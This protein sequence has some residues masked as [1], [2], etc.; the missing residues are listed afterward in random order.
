MQAKTKTEPYDFFEPVFDGN[1][2]VPLDTDYNLPD[3]CADIQRILKCR[4]VP[5]ISS[6][7][8][9]GDRVNCDGVCD[10]RVMYLDVRGEG[11][12]CCDFTKEFSASIPS[13]MTSERAVACI[14]ASVQHMTCRAVSAR[15]IDLH[16]TLGLNVLAVVQ[17][18]DPITVAIDDESIEKK[19]EAVSASQAVNAVSHQ[20]TVED[21]V[22]LKSGKPPIENILRREAS[23]RLIE[24]SANEDRLHVNG[25]VDLSFLYN[26]FVDGVTAEKMSATI[27]FDQNIDCTGAD[28]DCLCDI[29]VICG[30]SSVQPKED[31]MGENTGVTVFAK[32]FVVGFLYRPCEIDVVDDAYSVDKPVELHYAQ[33]NFM[34]T[35]GVHN[36]TLKNKSSMVVSGEEIQ[37]ILDIWIE[38]AE[39]S[40]YCDKGKIN[41]RV[42]YN[43]C[44]LYM[45]DQNRI[46]YT[47]KGFDFNHNAELPDEKIKK[48]DSSA[49]T[50]IWE[51]RITDK[52]TVEISAETTVSTLLYTRFA[53]KQLVSADIDE[54]AETLP[55]ES[56]LLVYYADEGENLW[57]IAKS[58]KAL[59]SD[60][61]AQ[62][63]LETEQISKAG[64]IIICNR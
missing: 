5:E 50:E 34:Q 2:E 60:I 8:A 12:K 48:C 38:G 51:Y 40:S 29:K 47:E 24:V 4:A 57:D 54:E 63:D 11:I 44:M 30:E 59:I 32:L 35:Y 42:K 22:P 13:K 16:V 9:E 58:H 36:D 1:Y 56:K 27:D 20:F 41:Y 15:R 46:L 64:P 17:K 61:R 62:N 21:F 3:Y 6:Y 28:G 55:K 33:N 7:T 14:K 53:V 45:N 43:V 23:A 49:R 10:I 37:K 39:T 26:S 52:S 25:A 19:T 31:T 18:R